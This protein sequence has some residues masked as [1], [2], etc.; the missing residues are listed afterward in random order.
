MTPEE[1]QRRLKQ[2]LLKGLDIPSDTLAGHTAHLNK[3][4]RLFDDNLSDAE[5]DLALDSKVAA[6]K[7]AGEWDIEW[8][9]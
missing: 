6:L 4:P 3:N 2:W 7:A 8:G 5:L 9:D 1:T